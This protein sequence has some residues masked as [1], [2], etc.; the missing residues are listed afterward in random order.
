M[1]FSQVSNKSFQKLRSCSQYLLFFTRK[2]KQ[3][4]ETHFSSSPSSNGC[5][6]K[7]AKK[8]KLRKQREEEELERERVYIK[9][10]PKRKRERNKENETDAEKLLSLLGDNCCFYRSVV[11]FFYFL[12]AERSLILFAQTTST[13]FSSFFFLKFYILFDFLSPFFILFLQFLVLFLFFKLFFFSSNHWNP[14]LIL[15]NIL[16]GSKPTGDGETI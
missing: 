4:R 13:V 15:L 2:I 7:A 11:V 3:N 14:F 6:T 10:I 9:K 8:N 16:Y 1:Q 12:Y 5:L